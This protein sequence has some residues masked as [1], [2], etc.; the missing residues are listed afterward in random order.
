[1]NII[2]IIFRLKQSFFFQRKSQALLSKHRHLEVFMLEDDKIKEL[3]LEYSRESMRSLQ[4]SALAK[5]GAKILTPI[6]SLYSVYY[7]FSVMYRQH[8]FSVGMFPI[9]LEITVLNH[10]ARQ[11]H[12]KTWAVIFPHCQV[13]FPNKELIVL[14]RCVTT[15]SL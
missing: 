10:L 1:M 15:S 6:L 5:R 2:N 9:S 11:Q 13:A 12:I 14:L 7:N 8:R 3:H 4:R